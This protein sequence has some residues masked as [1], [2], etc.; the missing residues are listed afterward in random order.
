MGFPKYREFFE[1]Q[2]GNPARIAEK[3]REGAVVGHDYLLILSE[4]DIEL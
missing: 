4:S 1:G 2:L 3:S